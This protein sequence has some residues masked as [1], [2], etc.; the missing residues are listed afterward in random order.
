MSS[1]DCSQLD[2]LLKS[3]WQIND[4][5]DMSYKNLLPAILKTQVYP[6]PTTNLNLI[7]SKLETKN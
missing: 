7:A 3:S 4:P 6:N 1:A 2:E 5:R